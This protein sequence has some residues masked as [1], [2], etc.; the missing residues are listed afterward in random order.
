MARNERMAV[1]EDSLDDRKAAECA[2]EGPKPHNVYRS[3]R[4]GFGTVAQPVTEP[5]GQSRQEVALRHTGN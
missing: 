5:R 4:R 3:D 1:D 2:D